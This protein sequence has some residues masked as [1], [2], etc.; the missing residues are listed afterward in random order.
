[1]KT[2]AILTIGMLSFG[3]MLAQ[4][5]AWEGV[6][7]LDSVQVKESMPESVVEKTVLPGGQ[8][9]FNGNW[10][11]RF[12]LNAEGKA[13]Y[14]EVGF[15]E[16]KKEQSYIIADVPYELKDMAGNTA[17]LIIDGITDRKVLNI[18]MIS[19]NMMFIEQSFTSG[20]NRREIEISWKMYYRRIMNS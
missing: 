10:M 5:L 1:M 13:S 19:D 7:V 4:T 11:T 8:A 16:W 17:T 2:V 14:T 15:S 18:S 3:A 12:E 6:W 9:L 20:Y